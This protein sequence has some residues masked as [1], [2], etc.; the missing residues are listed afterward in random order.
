MRGLLNTSK[1][2]AG[3][4]IVLLTTGGVFYLYESSEGSL[5]KWLLFGF[6]IFILLAYQYLVAQWLFSIIPAVLR[7]HPYPHMGVVIAGVPFYLKISVVVYI[8]ADFFK[9]FSFNPFIPITQLSFFETLSMYVLALGIAYIVSRKLLRYK[10]N[11]AKKANTVE[12]ENVE[13]QEQDHFWDDLIK[14]ISSISE[15]DLKARIVGQDR[16]ITQI[17]RSLKVATG[18]LSTEEKRS[19]V[20]V[21]MIF[22]G[23]TGVGKTETAKVLAELLKPLGYQF[24]RIDLNQYR[25]PES[26]WTLIGSPRGYVGS[27]YG[28]T[29]TRALMKNPKAVILFDEMEKAHPDLHTTFMTLL[30]E[31]YI[32]EQS[33]G[34]KVYL[35]AGIIIFTSNLYSDRIAHIAET[36]EDELELELQLRD[37][38]E[39]Y[40]GRP[41]IV[42]RIDAIVPFRRLTPEDLE[43]IARRVLTPYGKAYLAHELTLEL[44]GLAQRYGVRA[45]VRK[46]KEIA[47]TNPEGFIFKRKQRLEASDDEGIDLFPDDI[48]IG[49]SRG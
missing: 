3:L 18:L 6:L 38:A 19:R 29:L 41:E 32:E 44:L 37:F 45:F 12:V 22:V 43:E 35:Q 49:G 30:D 33:T 27:E 26:A 9:G 11:V 5:V 1:G 2:L 17:I 4:V 34:R 15:N 31:G 10:G 8:L 42:G 46:L 48:D 28:G 36:V 24:I 20:L 40:F 7:L 14:T 13:K 25:T 39:R 21:S 23:A 16:A 47:V